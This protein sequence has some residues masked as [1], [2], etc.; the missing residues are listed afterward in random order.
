MRL[1]TL[2]RL[3]LFTATLYTSAAAQ[4]QTS[5]ESQ[6]YTGEK[7]SFSYPAGWK[8]IDKSTSQIQQLNL[9]PQSGNI[10]IMVIAYR[11]KISAYEEIEQL[12]L[13][14]TQPQ[15]EKV[16]GSFT[17]LNHADTCTEIRN[18]KILG[19]RLK[20]LYNNKE[21]T[22]DFYSFVLDN[23]FINIVTLKENQESS[24]ADSAFELI[25]KTIKVKDKGSKIT[26]LP[27]NDF[28][29]RTVLNSKAASLVKPFYPSG[30]KFAMDSK[31]QVVITIDENGAVISAKVISGDPIFHPASIEAAKKSK[32]PPTRVCGELT[33]VSGIIVY[34]FSPN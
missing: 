33:K 22:S 12:D 27:I 28:K 23:K 7:L 16:S 13:A 19:L 1:K 14:I 20:G 5:T 31:V 15:I 32:F 21:A 4:I 17:A 18:S 25:Y 34:N 6:N 8:I 3:F 26:P 30:A 24:T 29:N 10:L 2:L 11:P 9:V